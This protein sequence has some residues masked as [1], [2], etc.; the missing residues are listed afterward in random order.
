MVL[1]G[2]QAFNLLSI[3]LLILPG[4][5]GTKLYLRG[6]NRQ[7]RFGRLDTVV[8][9]IT[10]SLAGLLLIYLGYWIYLG[11]LTTDALLGS[12]PLWKN[13]QCRVDA[14]PEQVFHYLLLVLLVAGGGHGLGCC[15]V[16]MEQLPDAPNKTWR[17]LFEGTESDD[18]DGPEGSFIRLYTASG[19][20][21]TGE[22][23]DWSV[24]SRS[25]LLKNAEWDGDDDGRTGELS[26]S[27]VYFHEDEV[28]R[29]H[30]EE[31]GTVDES[32][33]DAEHEDAE[34]NDK[35]ENLLESADGEDSDE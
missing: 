17:T 33:I 23:D 29:V 9:S 26:G 22:I 20:E 34:P 12:A 27:R 6:V 14:L 3:L 25:V 4:L 31:P 1:G 16:L 32:S 21:V 15:G 35:T 13:L 18:G 2:V 24:D 30:A 7:D 11:S 8:I 10:G 28:T 5:G 19:N